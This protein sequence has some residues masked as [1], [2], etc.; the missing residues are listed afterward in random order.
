MPYC[1]SPYPRKLNFKT[2]HCAC[3]ML[4]ILVCTNY[5]VCENITHFDKLL[6]V[7]LCVYTYSKRSTAYLPAVQVWTT[8]QPHP[9]KDVSFS[10][11]NTFTFT[12]HIHGYTSKEGFHVRFFFDG[13]DEDRRALLKIVWGT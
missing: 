1:L 8:D 13:G 7:C 10:L 4:L 12:L 5:K 2:K 3:K 11:L 6:L 9:Q